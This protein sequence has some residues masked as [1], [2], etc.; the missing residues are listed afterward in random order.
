MPSN[1]PGFPLPGPAANDPGPATLVMPGRKV[2]AG[3]GVDWVADGWKLFRKA[4]LMW[5]VFLVLFLLVQLGFGMVPW[6]GMWAG[7]LVSPILMGGIALGCRSLETGGELELEHMLAGFRRNTGMLFAIGVVYV[8]GE[9]VLLT[10]F[11]LFTGWTFLSAVLRGDEA[12]IISSMPEDLLWLALGALVT[13]SLALPL[14]AAYWFAPTLAMLHDVPAIPAMK[15]SLVACLRNFVPMTVYGL[16]ML[17]LLVV[18]VIPL[19]LGLI[20]WAPLL[21]ATIYASYRSVF[22]EPD[23]ADI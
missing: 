5:I 20:V 16:V 17:V 18:A 11:S 12:A 10:V 6:V 7:N 9:M 19:G 23:V 15:A 2:R 22:T 1:E 13:T 8:L 14:M 3:A 21:L 4:S